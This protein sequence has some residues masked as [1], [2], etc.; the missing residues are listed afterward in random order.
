MHSFFYIMNEVVILSCNL[1]LFKA[2]APAISNSILLIQL[3]CRLWYLICSKFLSFRLCAFGC[4]HSSNIPYSVVHKCDWSHTPAPTNV[5]QKTQCPYTG[6]RPLWCF[7]PGQFIWPSLDKLPEP[8]NVKCW[9]LLYVQNMMLK[10]TQ[11]RPLTPRCW[12][13]L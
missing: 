7:S 11:V 2:V 9:W 8:I 13:L 4:H 6:Q 3:Y 12:L 5:C 1:K 10:K